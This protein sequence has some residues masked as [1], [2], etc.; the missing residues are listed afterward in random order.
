MHASLQSLCTVRLMKF[1]LSSS[2]AF[3]SW[4]GTGHASCHVLPLRSAVY[5]HNGISFSALN[6]SSGV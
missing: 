2:P 1:L 5:L 3:E 4:I 6:G